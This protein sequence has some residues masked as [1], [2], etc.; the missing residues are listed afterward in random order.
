MTAPGNRHAITTL[1]MVI[2]GEAVAAADGGVFDV[3]SPVTG[4]VIARV[5]RGGPEDVDRAVAAAQAAFDG[6]WHTWSQTRRGQ[7]LGRFAHAD[8]RP[9]RGAGRHRVPEHGQAHQL[10]ALGDRRRGQRDGVLRRRREQ[11]H[12]RDDPGL[13]ARLRLHPARADRRRGP[14][15]AVELPAHAGQLED[16][17]GPGGRQHRDPQ[18]RQLH[19]ADRHPRRRAGARGRLPARRPQRRHR[20]GRH[21]SGRLSPRTPAS[22]RSPSPARRPRARRSC[23]RP[24]AT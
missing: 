23:E 18:A 3:V 11:D 19:A 20:P 4:Q 14:D 16:G 6:E 22:A 21:A 10:G 17:P 1:N 7:T 15:R 5:P 8:P 2:G 9:P 13:Q 12:G 24:P